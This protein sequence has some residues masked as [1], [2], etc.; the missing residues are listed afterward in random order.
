MEDRSIMKI[1]FLHLSDAHLRDNTNLNLINI[2]AII[3]S[4]SVLGNFDEC[5]LVFS[6]DIVDAGD[7]NSYAN[8]G[9]LIGYLAKGVSQ[10]Y[11]GGKIVQTLI[12]PGNHDNLVKNKDRDNLELESYYENK[13]VDIKFNEELEQLSNFYE[14][15]KKNR[16]FR[17]SKVIDVRKIKYGNFTIK[18]NL[19]NSAPFSLLGS[20]NRDKGMHFMPL[21]EIQKLN[22]NMNQKYTVSIIHHGPEWFSNAS[23]ESLYNTLNETTD[24]LF[25][26]H[27]HFALN[28]DKTVNGKH[29]DVSSGIALYGTKTEHG[30]NALILNTDEH[31][32]LG[33]KYIYNGKIYKPSKVIDNKNVVFNTNSGFKFTTEFRKEIITDSNER[34]GEKYGRYFVFP[35]LESKE[36]NSNLKS[37]TV[38]SEEKFKELMK[39]KNKISIQGGTRTGKS[40]LAKHLTNKLSED[41]T[42]LFMNEESFAP[43][44]KKNIMKNALQNEF[45]DEVD[46]DEF[47]QL[48]K[49]KKTLIV[50]GSDKVDKEKW[51]SFLSEY[52]E[53]FGH[54]ITFCDVDWSLNIKERTVEELTENA[55][56]YLKICPYYYVKREQLI[57]KIC[58]NYLDEYPTLDVDE[59]SR[60]INEEIT[61]Q[62]KYFQLTPDF[63]HQ[64]VDYYIQFSHIKTQNETNVFSKVF[65]ANIV[66]RISRNIKQEND[67]DEI[68]I[69]LEYVS[70]Y[71]HFIK[72]YQK[73]TYN[74]FKLAVE[75][76][77]KRYDNEELNIKYVYDV[78]VKANIIKE[79]TS[80]FEVEFCDKNL[81]AYFVALYLNRTCQ[82]KGKLNDLQEVLDNICFGINGDIILFLSYITN[83]TQILKPILNSIFTHMDDWEELDFDKN[84]IQYLSKASTTAMPKLPSNK[85]KEKL[86]E[87]KNR[88]EKEFIK[89]KE[90]QADSLYSYDA[91]KVNS[92]SNK[93]AKS[94]NYLDLVAKILPNFRFMLQGEEK[95]IITNILY[96]YPNKLLYFMLKDIDEN[97]NKIINDILKSKPKTRKGILITEDMITRELQNQSIAYILSIYDFVSMTAS[98]SKTIGDLEKF[99]YNCNTNY[100]IQNLMMQENIANFNVFAS[101]AEQLYDN[102]KLP[103][104]KQIITLIVRK[105]FIY[106]DVEMHGDAIH[107]I[108]KIFGEEQRQHFQILQAKNQI[109]KK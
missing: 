31:T 7:K 82:M 4:L 21:A 87:E 60:K 36:T 83:N 5:V 37:L 45:G 92:F 40:I 58:S 70:Y 32:L 108:D 97:S 67:I 68:L 56:Y 99:D 96:K 90:Q 15:A 91:S 42:V 6:G 104:I 52:S 81:L 13:Q 27:E 79:S 43:K 84:N 47:F 102:A 69:A 89:E 93:I 23:K 53:Q 71:I 94:I 41:Y 66:Y 51:D 19:I 26:G 17:K 59:K 61:N 106:H 64:F 72:K 10:R 3:N 101:R 63:I 103:L 30:F 74:E 29:I 50:D 95:R 77:K 75:E 88:I 76:Y 48:E 2:N 11:I 16:C 100:K 46:I 98:T 9:R 49:E 109:I 107:L 78:A 1:L 105:Y 25:V 20:G 34:E 35:S 22:I 73:I 24:L 54:I 18:V 62:I 12:V 8:A 44:N 86:K 55:F 85:D 80:D 14:F 28:E 65:A 38:T 57:K 33:Y 39:I